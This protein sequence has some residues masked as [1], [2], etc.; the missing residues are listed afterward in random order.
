MKK[1]HVYSLYALCM[2]FFLYSCEPE[3]ISEE[4]TPRPKI[5][6]PKSPRDTSA[7]QSSTLA[8]D[9]IH[10]PSNYFEEKPRYTHLVFIRR[11]EYPSLYSEEEEKIYY[12]NC[13][14]IRAQKMATYKET[15]IQK[16][17]PN[18]ICCLRCFGSTLHHG[19]ERQFFYGFRSSDDIDYPIGSNLWRNP[20]VCL[21]KIPTFVDDHYSF[22]IHK[23]SE[24]KKKK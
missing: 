11:T 14:Y 19:T 13:P 21:E 12:F 4:S 16:A 18:T 17:I 1:Y 5:L 7:I 15:S 6:L 10:S 2:P 9:I 23:T 20:K 3:K 8:T 24:S 22:T